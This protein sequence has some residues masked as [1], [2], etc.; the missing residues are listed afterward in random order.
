[1][2]VSR[3]DGVLDAHALLKMCL[4]VFCDSG[5]NQ[6]KRS[7]GQEEGGAAKAARRPEK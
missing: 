7:A 1:M 2:N 4:L 3:T 5:Q 6:G